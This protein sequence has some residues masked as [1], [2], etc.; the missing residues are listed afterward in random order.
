MASLFTI[1]E[2]GRN[3]MNASSPSDQPPM[4]SQA[5]AEPPFKQKQGHINHPSG[6]PPALEI[7]VLLLLAMIVLL[8][9]FL[10]IQAV[11]RHVQHAQDDESGNEEEERE[12]LS[13]STILQARRKERRR[14][15]RNMPISTPEPLDPASARAHYRELLLT[16]FQHQSNLARHANETPF[17]YQQRLTSALNHIAVQTEGETPS[18][19]AILAELTDAY[20][21]ER[22]GS[23]QLNQSQKSFLSQWIPNLLRHLTNRE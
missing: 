11:L 4:T 22:Y 20:V 6:I 8:I 19:P 14:H 10:I 3:G 16:T 17:E 12:S 5:S 9:V 13:M 1:V 2:E 7:I 21:S 23:E 18:D 15:Q